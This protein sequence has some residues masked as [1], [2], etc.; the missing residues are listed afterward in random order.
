M[1]HVLST[2]LTVYQSFT[3][4]LCV[5]KITLH[6]LI[7]RIKEI[8]LIAPPK[9]SDEYD[10][11]KS[12][13]N[14]VTVN[15]DFNGKPSYKNFNK[16]TGLLFCE[17]DTPKDF[18]IE[19]RKELA[20]GY[21]SKYVVLPFVLASYLSISK[22]SAHFIIQLD[23]ELAMDID[24]K[25]FK[26][27]YEFLNKTYFDNLL[28][29]QCKTVNRFTCISY[30]P[31]ILVNSS[32]KAIN[33]EDIRPLYTLQSSNEDIGALYK[34]DKN[35]IKGLCPLYQQYPIFL[36]RL[37]Y[38]PVKDDEEGYLSYAHDF[39][40]NP[41]R[42]GYKKHKYVANYKTCISEQHFFN[43][44][45]FDRNQPVFY[46][47][48]IHFCQWV[49]RKKKVEEGM[50]KSTLLAFSRVILFN[51]PFISKAHFT[52]SLINFNN[53]NIEDPL[54]DFEVMQEADYNFDMFH[55]GRMEF[56]SETMRIR[57]KY[58]WFSSH[59]L[60]SPSERISI[61]RKV[62]KDN[63]TARIYAAIEDLQ[64]IK[65]IT[66][67]NIAESVGMTVRTVRRHLN[68]N[69]ALLQLCLEF[70]PHI[71]KPKG[72]IETQLEEIT[73]SE[74]IPEKTIQV[75]TFKELFDNLSEHQE[76]L[77]LF[78]KSFKLTEDDLVSDHFNSDDSSYLTFALSCIDPNNH[79]VS[80][81]ERGTILTVMRKHFKNISEVDIIIYLDAKGIPHE[82][83]VMD[84][85]LYFIDRTFLLGHVIEEFHQMVNTVEA[86]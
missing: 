57:K 34:S 9:D 85:S 74:V 32:P 4:P 59:C 61:S 38:K 43:G 28:D 44:I 77:N 29:N 13:Q 73:A 53:W 66:Q 75:G 41:R 39:L 47:D 45:E 62:F 19:E 72:K 56:P 12:E 52:Q 18:S 20:V 54:L 63:T 3:N 70:N 7:T 64:G 65:K 51:T 40:E 27:L 30:D 55:D 36:E 15:G 81:K 42:G 21:K 46:P 78:Y 14:V 22:T 71:I 84:S 2:P 80:Q 82:C 31:D 1:N 50:R 17:I 69:P 68:D 33:K 49:V 37:L 23:D 5:K 8:K 79:W 76:M 26:R 48:G 60:L 83:D 10:R 16:S 25:L 11:F 58:V 67:R 35:D 86:A 24:P 6:D